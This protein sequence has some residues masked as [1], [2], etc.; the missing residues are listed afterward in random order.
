MCAIE[1]E[2]LLL[3][4]TGRFDVLIIDNCFQELMVAQNVIKEELSN[5]NYS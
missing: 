4:G 3:K 1:T 2:K 5:P